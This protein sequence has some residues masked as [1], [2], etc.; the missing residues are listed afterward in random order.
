M[1]AI[2][3]AADRAKDRRAILL[4]LG[5][6][7]LLS[8]LVLWAAGGF[9][10]MLA[11]GDYPACHLPDHD[12][13]ADRDRRRGRDCNTASMHCRVRLWG[14][15]KFILVSFGAGFIIQRCSATILP[16]LLAATVLMLVGTMLLPKSLTARTRPADGVDRH[17][18][19]SEAMALFRAPH[20]LLFLLAASAVQQATLSI[21]RS[22]PSPAASELLG[23][24][25]RCALGL[26]RHRRDCAVRLLWKPDR[27]AR[28]R[29][30]A[31]H[32]CARCNRP[33]G[34]DGVRAAAS[35][36]GAGAGSARFQFRR[37]ASRRHPFLDACCA[38]RSRGD[39]ARHGCRGRCRR[40]GACDHRLRSADWVFGPEVMRGWAGTCFHLSA[41]CFVA[42]A[43]LAWR[44]GGIRCPLSF[45]GHEFVRDPACR[46]DG[47]DQL[48]LALVGVSVL[49]PAQIQGL[50]LPRMLRPAVAPLTQL[51]LLA[52]FGVWARQL[53]GLMLAAT[54]S[55]CPELGDKILR[56]ALADWRWG[57][58]P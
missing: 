46:S 42:D 12:H 33:L 40:H 47:A 13:A 32:R 34:R 29:A 43:P 22:A 30:A 2:S 11:P 56:P 5:G 50:A 37:R 44:L 55:R 35:G 18:K 54:A 14:S 17:L 51:L 24:D 19:L 41:F 15:A 6:G 36:D 4:M 49:D 8:F 21:M 45:T 1:P 20:F 3:F 38:G 23:R 28:C 53:V 31:R 9:W 16:L 58:Q 48:P 52:P 27:E 25:D 57:A 10:P 7:S 39:R 26:R